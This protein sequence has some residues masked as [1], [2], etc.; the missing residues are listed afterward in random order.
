MSRSA[1]LAAA[2]VA[3]SMGFIDGSAVNVALPIVQ[4]RLH[5]S[6]AEVQWIVEGYALFLS[7]LI[8]IG[9]ALGDRYGRRLLF[10]LGTWLFT[11]ASVACALASDP[12]FL[13]TMRCIQGIG[14]AFMIPGSLALITATFDERT[15]G[16]AIGI[17]S[18]A[19]AITMAAGP[20][21]GGW[22][23]QTLTWRA[24]FLINVPLAA[25]VLWLTY[26]HV[27]ESCAADRD[28]KPDVA[29]SVCITFALGLVTL[30]LIQEQTGETLPASIALATGLLAGLAFIVVERHAEAPIVPLRLF[31]SRA[32][33]IANFYTLLLYAALGGVLFFMPFELINVM[34]YTPTAAGAAMLPTI[35]LIG[36]LSPLTGSIAD[37]TGARVPMIAGAA[38]AAIGFALF[39]RL[40]AGAAYLTNVLPASV[41]LGIGAAIFVSPLTT[42]VM[43][44]T[45]PDDLGAASGVNNAVSRTAGLIAIALIGI[46]VVVVAQHALPPALQGSFAGP[47]RQALLTGASPPGFTRVQS[48]ALHQAYTRGFR[49][50]MVSGGMLAAG[51]ALIALLLP[52]RARSLAGLGGSN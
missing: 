17:W 50:A 8:L 15:R 40:G 51:A 37:R 39:T 25:V 45:D 36:A 24:I 11:S 13:V 21:L 30:G 3:S 27:P 7:A 43:N 18:A 48:L 22:L 4:A 26:L 49:A 23:T 6:A 14:G 9:G 28:G 2:I 38:V 31:A 41:V 34:G 10:L 16:R 32:F 1:V 44:A 19:S 47:V 35:G 33:T 46:V 12:A 29:G 52:R 42:A 5:A 20:V